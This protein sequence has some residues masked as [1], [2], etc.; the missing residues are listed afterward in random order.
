[1]VEEK[2]A[3]THLPGGQ[4]LVALTASEYEATGFMVVGVHAAVQVLGVTRY[5]WGNPRDPHE[6]S[7]SQGEE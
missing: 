4:N 7:R 2:L 1:M 6:K 3:G 5:G